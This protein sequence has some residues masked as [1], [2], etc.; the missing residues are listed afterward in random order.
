L[1]EPVRRSTD[2]MQKRVAS[3]IKDAIISGEFKPGDKLPPERELAGMLKV[4]RGSLREALVHLEAANLVQI[5]H[6]VGVFIKDADQ[7]TLI[8]EFARQL[9]PDEIMIKELF[10]IR[11][12][13]EPQSA[14]WAAERGASS[15]IQELNDLLQSVKEKMENLPTGQLAVLAKHDTKF[16]LL[17]AEAS[18]NTIAKTIM[19]NLMGALAESRAKAMTVP[20]RAQKSLDDHIYIARMISDRDPEAAENAMRKHLQEV[21]KDVVTSYVPG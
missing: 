2:S 8:A 9:V 19:N 15:I 4:S 17:I 7:D 16:H 20:G 14:A 18:G 11:L 3:V 6:G 12:L 5:R 1:F 13:L 21:A 10:E